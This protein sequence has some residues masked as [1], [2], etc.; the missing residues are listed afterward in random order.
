MASMAE[1][2]AALELWALYT[3]VSMPDPSKAESI[4]LAKVVAF[5]G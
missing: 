5:T 1:E 3:D 4:H 2:A